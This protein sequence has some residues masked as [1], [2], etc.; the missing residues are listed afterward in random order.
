MYFCEHNY[1]SQ[2]NDYAAVVCGNNSL[3]QLHTHI[4][5]SY[6][7]PDVWLGL[8]LLWDIQFELLHDRKWVCQPKNF[9]PPFW[10]PKIRHWEQW[11]DQRCKMTWAGENWR[12]DGKRKATIWKEREARQSWG[13]QAVKNSNRETENSG[14]VGWW[15]AYET[16]Q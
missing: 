12:R 9:E 3:A 15:K 4:S 14:G 10:I 5:V 16:L 7:S 6:W 2:S 1:T 13:K 11:L 8:E